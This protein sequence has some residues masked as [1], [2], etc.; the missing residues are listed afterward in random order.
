MEEKENQGET[1]NVDYL[2]TNLVAF[3]KNH[4]LKKITLI[5]IK[6]K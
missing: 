1:N 3:L 6:Y 2:Q 4:F 5:M